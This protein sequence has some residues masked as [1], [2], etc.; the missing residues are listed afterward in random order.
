MVSVIV[1]VMVDIPADSARR[2]KDRG[3]WSS[4]T[5]WLSEYA[6][7]QQ[8]L[9][10]R[11]NMSQS[12]CQRKRTYVGLYECATTLASG[13][14]GRLYQSKRMPSFFLLKRM[15]E[16][17]SQKMSEMQWFYVHVGTNARLSVGTDVQANIRLLIFQ[18][19]S[20]ASRPFTVCWTLTRTS[21][22][23]Q[24]TGCILQKYQ[25]QSK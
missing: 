25:N 14:C 7:R 10:L 2:I 12:L 24:V 21:A 5:I 8:F 18:G 3:W 11:I 4:L 9:A 15:S 19:L 1:S 16:H 22:R 20:Q 6:T 17:V 23:T 13:Q